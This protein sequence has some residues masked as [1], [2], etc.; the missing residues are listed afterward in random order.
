MQSIA[1][2][3]DIHGNCTALD[4]VLSD[5][6]SN[7]A[8]GVVCLGDA[9]QGGP[10]PTQV[11]QRLRQLGCPVVMGNADAWMLTGHE[12]SPTETTTE[13]QK[14]VRD[15]QLAQLSQADKDFIAAFK[16]TVEVALEG[17]VNLLCFHGS[18]T[19]FD[20]I[21]L[22]ETPEEEFVGFLG[23]WRGR[24]MTGGHTHLQQIRRLGDYFF[25]NPG[26]VGVTYDR[27]QPEEN[28]QLD[29]WAEYA[30]LTSHEGR[31]SLEFRRVPVDVD[32]RVETLIASGRPY[33]DS[34]AAQYGVR[35]S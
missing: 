20:D 23:A 11:V 32:K 12:T 7:P 35:D 27:H 15:W 5:L 30:V 18:P 13:K 22:P 10:Q 28:V 31:L 19:S 34:Y 6:A 16:P 25:F 14:Q 4:A 2:I 3:S 33:A 24:V 1:I 29:H 21:I 17:G 9:I 26:S 8:E